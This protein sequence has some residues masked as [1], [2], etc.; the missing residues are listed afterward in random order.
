LR[1]FIGD[2]N[3][4]GVQ[5]VAIAASSE[6]NPAFQLAPGVKVSSPKSRTQS[7]ADLKQ[8]FEAIAIVHGG[9]AG[10]QNSA[11]LQRF[12]LVWVGYPSKLAPKNS[13]TRLKVPLPP[14]AKGDALLCM[15]EGS[16]D[17]YIYFDGTDYRFKLLTRGD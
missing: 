10:W 14:H 15:G 5:D 13:K 7:P 4:D 6:G 17:G 3:G 2:F 9:P 8:R 1:Y 11:S 16:G 12:L